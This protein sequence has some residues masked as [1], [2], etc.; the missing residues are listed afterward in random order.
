MQYELGAKRFQ[1][2][3]ISP[4]VFA[5]FATALDILDDIGMEDVV[6]QIRSLADRLKAGIDDSRL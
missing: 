4:P 1:S 5:E 6:A 2:A 3:T